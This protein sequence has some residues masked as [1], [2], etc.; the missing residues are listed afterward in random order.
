MLTY[1]QKKKDKIPSTYDLVIGTYTTGESKGIYVY[2]FYTETGKLAYLSQIE[3]VDNPSYLC[4][5]DNKF[6]YAVNED[7]KN[8]GVVS[9]FKFEPNQGKIEFINKQPSAGADPCYISVDKD[10]KNVFVANYS[11]GALSVLPINK[12][13]SL[14]AP[15]QVIQDTGQGTP[16]TSRQKGPHVHMAFLSPDEKYLL[17]TDLGTDK[18]NVYRYH[19]SQAAAAYTC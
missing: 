5:S 17:Y 15:S 11:S 3:G 13:G 18:L 4:V 1:A 7:G 19:A 16:D 6:I 9:A 10:Q 2:R 8:G 12:D 14:N